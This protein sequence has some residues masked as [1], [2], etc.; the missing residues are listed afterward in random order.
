MADP[1]L[2]RVTAEYLKQL[3]EDLD[4]R[5]ERLEQLADASR[6]RRALYP[7]AEPPPAGRPRRFSR[8]YP[9]GRP[10]PWRTMRLRRR[11]R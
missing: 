10:N 4:R 5:I 6:L 8:Q 9:G 2:P 11:R 1:T 3:A 7:V